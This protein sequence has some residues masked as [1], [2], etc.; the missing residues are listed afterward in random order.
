LRRH[1]LIQLR[2]GIQPTR[3]N[4]HRSNWFHR[5]RF[6]LVFGRCPVRNSTQ[7]PTTQTLDFRG[8]P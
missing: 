5:Q 3:C 6:W 2:V 4:I 7:T 1:L 8:F